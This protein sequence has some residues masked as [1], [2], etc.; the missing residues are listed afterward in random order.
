MQKNGISSTG[1]VLKVRVLDE[2]IEFYSI[3]GMPLR[4]EPF[5]GNRISVFLWPDRVSGGT[6]T[7]LNPSTIYH[8][9]L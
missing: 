1:I 6:K 3:E 9:G 2:G 8:R 5:T 4:Y 7:A